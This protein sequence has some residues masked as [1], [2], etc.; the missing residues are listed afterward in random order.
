MS[1]KDISL[2]LKWF[3][4]NREQVVGWMKS[5]LKDVPEDEQ[6]FVLMDSTHAVNVAMM[7][8]EKLSYIIPLKRNNPY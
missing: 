5:L 7:E 3:G 6:N 2:N 4:E 8:E 1:D